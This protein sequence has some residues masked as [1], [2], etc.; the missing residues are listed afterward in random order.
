MK[1]APM[2]L[3]EYQKCA[4]ETAEY[5]GRNSLAG[6]TY[7]VLKLN[8]EAGE[9]AELLG[10][11]YR[12][13]DSDIPQKH[14]EPLT[15]ITG[16]RRNRMINELGDVLWYVSQVA[17]ELEITLQDVGENNIGR[18]KERIKIGKIRGDGSDR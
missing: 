17:H 8:G 3:N 2:T 7:T 10:K 16:E 12:G 9:V 11:H 4:A 6:L 18:L 13:D 5:N 14:G 1:T 15:H